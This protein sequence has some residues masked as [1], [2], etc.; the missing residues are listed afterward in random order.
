MATVIRYHF[1]NSAFSP[2]RFVADILHMRTLGTYEQY[3]TMHFNNMPYAHMGLSFLAWHRAFLWEFERD[4][5]AADRHAGRPGTWPKD[6]NIGVPYWD[7]TTENSPNPAD[8]RGRLWGPTFM[9]GSGSPVTGPFAPAA[10]PPPSL[11]ASSG[12]TGLN[13]DLGAIG[14]LSNTTDVNYALGLNTFDVAPFTETGP[15]TGTTP[16][17]FRS[18]VEGQ[19]LPTNVPL[20]SGPSPPM[21]S[22]TARMHNRGHSWVGGIMNMVPISPYDPVFWLNHSNVDRLWVR[23]QIAHSANAG[24]WPSDAAIDALYPSTGT[25]P[26][27]VFKRSEYMRPWIPPGASRGWRPAD[28]LNWQA[29]GPSSE[30]KYRY[31]TD[32]PGS[33]RFS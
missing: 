14:V 26:R 21:H 31:D 33:F 20:G 17:S 10:W 24:Q 1:L 18:V 2:Q 23:W 29:M 22:S 15:N 5:Q 32:P 16:T 12:V 9:G 8:A 27:N 13:R 11:L 7:W 19:T 28:V 25:R 3:I 4:L 6:G 30:H